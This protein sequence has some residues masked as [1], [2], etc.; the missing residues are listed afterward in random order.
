M[1]SFVRL[2]LLVLV[3]VLMLVFGHYTTSFHSIPHLTKDVHGQEF[4]PALLIFV[5]SRKQR[6]PR[7]RKRFERGCALGQSI[8][9][10]TQDLDWVDLVRLG[11]GGQIHK[12]SVSCRQPGANSI[13][14]S[15][16]KLC[17]VW[18]ETDRDLYHL[19]ASVD[20]CLRGAFAERL[21][22]RSGGRGGLGLRRGLGLTE[23]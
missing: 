21:S 5:K 12:A 20:Q 22:Y 6:L 19:D 10:V 14:D 18:C 15:R 23:R 7:I 9:A 16:P 4:Q 1:R 2:L 17:L 11:P 3:V 13:F 8:G